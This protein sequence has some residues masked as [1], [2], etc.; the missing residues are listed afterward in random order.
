MAYKKVYS[1]NYTKSIEKYGLQEMA[2]WF[3]TLKL[4]MIVL[5]PQAQVACKCVITLL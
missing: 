4:K 2:W 1:N 5:H 3:E